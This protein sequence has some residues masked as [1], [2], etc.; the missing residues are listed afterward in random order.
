MVDLEAHG[1]PAATILAEGGVNWDHLLVIQVLS[2][3][4]FFFFYQVP[5]YRPDKEGHLCGRALLWLSVML[6]G[7]G[8][9]VCKCSRVG[10]TL[11]SFRLNW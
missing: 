7:I 1:L 5:L 4:F 8:D 2:S 10:V 11:P 3:F 6:S 9:N